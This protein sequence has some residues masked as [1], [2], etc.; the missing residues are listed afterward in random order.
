MY[1]S[2]SQKRLMCGVES[3]TLIDNVLTVVTSSGGIYHG[4]V[5]DFV[6]CRPRLP[7]SSYQGYKSNIKK[8]Q[9]LLLNNEQLRSVF[10]RLRPPTPAPIK[11]VDFQPRIF[12][13]TSYLP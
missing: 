11:K 2:T 4:P 3:W 9:L 10:D 1:S 7:A 8:N 5:S 13:T 12:F 6:E